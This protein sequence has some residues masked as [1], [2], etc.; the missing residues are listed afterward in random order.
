MM[1]QSDELIFSEGQVNHQLVYQE[2]PLCEY[3]Y[4]Q[5]WESLRVL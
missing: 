3:D 4:N 5:P 1:I 2:L